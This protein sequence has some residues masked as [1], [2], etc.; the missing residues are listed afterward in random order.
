MRRDQGA[1]LTINSWGVNDVFD[2][3][4]YLGSVPVLQEEM[5][6]AEA[7]EQCRPCSQPLGAGVQLWVGHRACV[8]LLH[9]YCAL[10]DMASWRLL[11]GNLT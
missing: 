7:C 10:L 2:T 3:P 4:A 8:Q 5:Q 6:S 9:K 1:R 11:R